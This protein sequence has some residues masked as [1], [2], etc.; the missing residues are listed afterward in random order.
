M[1]KFASIKIRERKKIKAPTI[2]SLLHNNRIGKEATYLLPKK[3]RHDNY[4]DKK[5]SNANKV[6]AEWIEKIEKRYNEVHK[7]KLRSDAVRIEEGLIVLSA[8]QVKQCSPDLIWAKMQQF[9]KWFEQRHNTEILSMDWH[10]DEGHVNEAGEAEHNEHCHFLFADVDKNGQKIRSSWKRSGEELREMQDKVA[11]LFEPL[12]FERGIANQKKEYRRPREQRQHKAKAEA[13]QTKAKLKDVNEENKRLREQLKAQSAGRE[14]YAELEKEIK[15][16]REQ[17]RSKELTIEQ[18]NARVRDLEQIAYTTTKKKVKNKLFK[19]TVVKEVK[20]SFREIA[21]EQ[22]AEIE[23]L[24][25]E[26]E[27]KERRIEHLESMQKTSNTFKDLQDTQIKFL[28]NKVETLKSELKREKTQNATQSTSESKK[29][30]QIANLEAE[31]EELKAENS[32]LKEKLEKVSEK[33]AAWRK[34]IFQ[35]FK[36][37]LFKDTPPPKKV[38]KEFVQPEINSDMQAHS[39]P[40]KQ[41]YYDEPSL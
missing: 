20:K 15:E 17:A 6:W 21:E 18:L 10:R 24:Q 33:L 30:A 35:K 26:I 32:T 1:A 31:N 2:H 5:I 9:K 39:E 16:L 37:D 41:T 29:D 38:E 12:G 19:K 7:R 34:F 23:T 36:L 11:E 22:A 27:Q 13:E 25:I 14:Q 28:E 40:P 3:Y 4:H 8:E